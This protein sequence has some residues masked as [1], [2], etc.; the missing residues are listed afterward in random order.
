[1]QGN[2]NPYRKLDEKRP[3]EM[4]NLERLRKNAKMTQQ[5]VADKLGCTAKTYA[6]YERLTTDPKY[7]KP[8]VE[9]LCA[10]ADMFE[11]SCDYILG[12]SKYSTDN[13]AY[14]NKLTGLSDNSIKNIYKLKRQLGMI[15]K[16]FLL[17]N[18]LGY[19]SFDNLLNL[20]TH[21]QDFIDA[22]DNMIPMYENENGDLIPFGYKTGEKYTTWKKDNHYEFYITNW[23][24]DGE[25]GIEKNNRST[26][27]VKQIPM[28]KRFLES[29]AVSLISEDLS[30]IR[31]ELHD[32]HRDF[33]L[34]DIDAPDT[35]SELRE[36]QN[37][38]KGSDGL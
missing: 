10:L 14:I 12:R 17:D 19:I 26:D 6:N 36:L 27:R 18:L 21:L 4:S 29:R 34:Y 25:T 1:M 23:L 11:V 31:T 9:H 33:W 28:D 5:Q 8:Y 32:N 20:L 38:M 37:Q 15:Q 16:G 2:V 24:M 13:N 22:G 3:K 30:K 7:Q 35:L